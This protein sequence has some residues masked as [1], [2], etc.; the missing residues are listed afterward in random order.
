MHQGSQQKDNHTTSTPKSS[1]AIQRSTFRVSFF[2]QFL[3]SWRGVVQ[4]I[5][6]SPLKLTELVQVVTPHPPLPPDS[7]VCVYMQL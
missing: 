5:G 2:F 6:G 3:Q 7:Y 4:V 1:M